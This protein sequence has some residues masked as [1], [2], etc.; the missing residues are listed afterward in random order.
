MFLCVFLSSLQVRELLLQSYSNI[1]SL[2]VFRVF[3]D[4]RLTPR[5]LQSLPSHPM[6]TGRSIVAGVTRDRFQM[7]RKLGLR[8]PDAAAFTTMVVGECTRAGCACAAWA[9]VRRESTRRGTHAHEVGTVRRRLATAGQI[10][11]TGLRNFINKH[12]QYCWIGLSLLEFD[13]A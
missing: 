5:H 6:Y 11:V 10:D 7:H 9:D 13:R 12:P 1:V 2:A 3:S 4:I 8:T